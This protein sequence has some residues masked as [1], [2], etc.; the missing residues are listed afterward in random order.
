MV[1]LMVAG[2]AA[3]GVAGSGA[4]HWLGL[5]ATPLSGREILRAKMLGAIWRAAGSS[6]FCWGSGRSGSLA[7][8]V[9]PLGF[10]A[11]LVG[12][13][14]LGAFFAALG[15]SAALGRAAGSGPSSE[16]SCPRSC[17]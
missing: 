4:R 6:A 10:L 2:S 16:L 3:E 5:I 17:C 8:A 14:A 12:L 7:G 1:A 13:V 15:T 9:H 11:E